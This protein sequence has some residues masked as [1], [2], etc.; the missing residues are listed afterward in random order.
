MNEEDLRLLQAAAGFN[1]SDGAN[2]SVSTI[3]GDIDAEASVAHLSVDQINDALQSLADYAHI[4][5]VSAEGGSQ[6]HKQQPPP[7]PQGGHPS[8]NTTNSGIEFGANLNTAEEIRTL[9][10]LLGIEGDDAGVGVNLKDQNGVAGGMDGKSEIDYEG[11]LVD[12]QNSLAELSRPATRANSP[13]STARS[14]EQTPMS[15]ELVV[16][17]DQG[18]PIATEQSIQLANWIASM[19]SLQPGSNSSGDPPLDA[20]GSN[21]R[22]RGRQSSIVDPFEDPVKAAE[23]ERI[24]VENRE[25]KKKWRNQ[26]Q[27]RSKDQ[28]F[29]HSII[30]T[31]PS[32]PLT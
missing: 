26:N 2:L 32:I 5:E 10:E 4:L 20:V 9:K 17:G 6:D 24:R 31:P 25:R 7:P 23:K 30:Y 22:S 14:T 29:D 19:A 12:L 18:R 27:E 1:S 13:P 8:P 28:R 15:S 3:V 11:Q 21:G 16:R